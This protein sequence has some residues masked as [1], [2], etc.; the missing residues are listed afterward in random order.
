MPRRL[1]S[2]CATSPDLCAHDQGGR[3]TLIARYAPAANCVRRGARFAWLARGGP[4]SAVTHLH[5]GGLRGA[6]MGDRL[7][8]PH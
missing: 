7:P 6:D 8:H 5:A 1:R 2:R 3:Q 4:A